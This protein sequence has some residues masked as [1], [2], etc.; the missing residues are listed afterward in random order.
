MLTPNY[1]KAHFLYRLSADFAVTM[2]S[3][4]KSSLAFNIA[5]DESTNIQDNSQL[6]IFFR[7]FSFEITVKEELLDWVAIRASTREVNSKKC[8]LA[9]LSLLRLMVQQ[10]RR[11]NVSD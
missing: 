4:L 6:A 8:L 10:Q 9:K 1:T 2:Q 11:V 7:Y 5:F 3:D